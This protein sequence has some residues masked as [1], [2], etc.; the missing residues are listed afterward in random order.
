MNTLTV[1]SFNLV[2]PHGQIL[3]DCY[4][5]G[6]PTQLKKRGRMDLADNSCHVINSNTFPLLLKNTYKQKS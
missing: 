1:F 6:F 4:Y 5:I 2:I 3:T